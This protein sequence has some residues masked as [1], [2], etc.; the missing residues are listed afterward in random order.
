AAEAAHALRQGGVV[1]DVGSVKRAIVSGIDHP[2]FVGGHP[3]AGSEQESVD[4]ADPE[5]FEGATWVLTPAATTDTAAY[6][7]VQ[8]IV[9]SFGADVVAIDAERHDDLVA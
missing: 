5:L 3:M 7:L 6:S 2:K 4:G 8:G 9:S 1:T